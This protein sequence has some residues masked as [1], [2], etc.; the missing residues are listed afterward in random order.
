MGRVFDSPGTPGYPPPRDTWEFPPPE[1]ST[2]WKWVAAFAG[3]TGLLVAGG[4]A[5]ALIVLGTEDFPGLIDDERLTDTI[6]AEC[7]VMTSTVASMPLSGGTPDQARTIRSQNRAVEVMV[8]SVRSANAK[9]I[10]DDR[11]AEQWLD[12]W[13]RL[14]EARA[15]YA[16]ELLDDPRATLEVPLDPDGDEITERMNDVWLGESG[17]EVPDVLVRPYTDAFSGA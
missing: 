5:A 12:D 14:V 17:C 8:R 16:R 1:V 11:P 10:R 15:D 4:L 3:V 13:E 6:A 2:R 7:K 9:E